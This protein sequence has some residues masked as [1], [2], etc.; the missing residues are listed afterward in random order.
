VEGKW[1]EERIEG[2][3]DRGRKMKRN[4]GKERG[5]GGVRRKEKGGREQLITWQ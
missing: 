2:K 1:R 5:K 4:N 3:H